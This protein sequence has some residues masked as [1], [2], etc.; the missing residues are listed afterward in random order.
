VA[1]FAERNRK[2]KASDVSLLNDDKTEYRYDTVRCPEDEIRNGYHS[3]HV[4]S[5]SLLH[6]FDMT[7]SRE[8]RLIRNAQQPCNTLPVP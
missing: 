3:T 7:H 8:T 4:W 5:N 1:G 2:D 6:M